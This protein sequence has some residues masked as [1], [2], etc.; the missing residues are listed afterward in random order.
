MEHIPEEF[1]EDILSEIERVS[2]R[3]LHGVDFGEQDDGFDQTHCTLH[4]QSWWDERMPKGQVACD[5]ESLE[6]FEGSIVTHVPVGDN[7]LKLNIGSCTIMFHHGWINVDV[8]PLEDFARSEGYKFLRHDARTRFPFEDGSVDLIYSAHFLEHLTYTEGKAFL[9]E[10]KRMLVPGGTV[11]I[12][13]PDAKLLV[14]HYNGDRMS[15]FDEINNECAASTSEAA[16]FWQLVF[17]GHSAAYDW[18]TLSELAKE[19]GLVASLKSFREGHPQ[20]LAET[21]DVL[22]C[23]SL[24]VEL[25]RPE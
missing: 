19:A 10:C 6:R 24:Y 2:N 11:R 18:I 25:T 22:P 1:L 4:E 12:A 8:L 7:K 16:K 14:E 21:L 17:N 5:K 20:I 13:V 15:K 23:L 3:G 9:K